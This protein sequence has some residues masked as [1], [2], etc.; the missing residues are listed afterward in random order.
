MKHLLIPVLAAA[1]LS[2][3]T[4]PVTA[5]PPNRPIDL[6]PVRPSP[7]SEQ[8]PKV[9]QAP[10][11]PT[12]VEIPEPFATEKLTLEQVEQRRKATVDATNLEEPVRNQIVELYRLAAEQL[13]RAR[14]FAEQR[15]EFERKIA[16]AEELAAGLQASLQ[17][18]P[19][20]PLSLIH[21]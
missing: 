21:I 10:Q 5:Q 20:V 18:E 6:R 2:L 15:S 17:S 13:T 14:S 7:V 3:T 4:M 11:P 1:L 16:G 9:E 8:Q 12:V 19:V